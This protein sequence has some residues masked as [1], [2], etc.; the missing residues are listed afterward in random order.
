MAESADVRRVVRIDDLPL[1][2]NSR[3]INAREVLN[4]P[5]YRIMNLVLSDG[6]VIPPHTSP[7]EVFFYVIQGA[8]EITIADT[9]HRVRERDILPCPK[10]TLM[11]VKAGAA[12]LSILNVKAPNPATL[13]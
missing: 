6:Q 4:T 5:P 12:G 13:A 3:G 2:V 10:D 7:V 8:G 11:S 9:V 1:S